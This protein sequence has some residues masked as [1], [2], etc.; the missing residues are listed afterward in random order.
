MFQLAYTSLFG[1][2]CAFLL[3]RTGA[4]LPS[5]LAHIFCNLMGLPQLGAHLAAFPARRRG[6]CPAPC[7]CPSFLLPLP[8]PHPH[9]F[10]SHTY[11]R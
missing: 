4:L 1:F 5:L 7:A 10:A 6:K 3:L 2:H 11:F 8:L 9:R